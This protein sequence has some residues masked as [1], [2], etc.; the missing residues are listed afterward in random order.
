LTIFGGVGPVNTRANKAS[1]IELNLEGILR[2]FLNEGPRWVRDQRSQ[3]RPLGR[4]LS[5]NE[6][7][8][9]AP[10]FEER[11][12]DE[13]RLRH[14]PVIQNPPFYAALSA[15]GVPIPLDFTLMSGITFDDT[16]LLSEQCPVET[17]SQLGLLFHELVHVVQFKRAGIEGFVERYV[18]G[19]AE[20]DFT[21]E[22]I[23][24]EAQAYALGARFSADPSSGFSVHAEVNVL[25]GVVS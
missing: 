11:I 25:L 20:N 22:R 10:F 6:K 23:P 16:I 5:V 3:H 1:D 7:T 18:L 15:P 17:A 4:A 14:V 9:L 24:L 19:W 13:A 12:L 2:L 21:Y 8:R